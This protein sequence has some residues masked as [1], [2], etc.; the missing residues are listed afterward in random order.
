MKK[1]LYKFQ[2]EK[3]PHLDQSQPKAQEYA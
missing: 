3:W 2:T 1:Q